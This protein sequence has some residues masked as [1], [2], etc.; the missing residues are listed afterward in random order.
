MDGKM[1]ALDESFIDKHSSNSS[2]SP[3]D[4]FPLTAYENWIEVKW[5]LWATPLSLGPRL[6]YNQ[7]V[8]PENSWI[9]DFMWVLHDVKE[10]LVFWF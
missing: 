10:P 4:C 3:N 5:L 2:E 6:I 1:V 7:R 9:R 8:E